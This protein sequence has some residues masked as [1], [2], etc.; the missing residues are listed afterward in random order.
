MKTYK[1]LM[2]KEAVWSTIWSTVQQIVVAASTYFIL[3]A[4]RHITSGKLELALIYIGAFV[5]SLVLVYLP[6]T[7]SMVYLQR[8]RL[9]SVESFVQSFIHH[10]KGQTS[11]GHTRNKVKA[12]SWLTNES[13]TVLDTA[14]N[15]L[16]QIY[17]TLMNSVFNI[18]VIA[19][20]L[21][22]RILAWYAFAGAVLVASNYFF[23][24]KISQTSLTVQESRNEL[25][26]S[27]LSAW[28][29]IFVGNAHNFEIWNSDFSKRMNKT[30]ISATSY[31]LTR[32]LIS[33][34]TVSI[35]L[36]IVATGNGIFLWENRQS[37]SLMAALLIT[38]PRQLQIIQSI[39]AFFNL[40]LSWTGTREQLKELEKVIHISQQPNESEKYVSFDAIEMFNGQESCI[41]PNLNSISGRIQNSVAGRWTLRG[42]NG[43]GKS[44][45][46]SLLKEDLA[47]TAFLLPTNYEDLAFEKDFLNHSDGNR[48][49]SVFQRIASLDHVK[50][51]ILDEWDAN[52]DGDN[53]NH[54]NNMIE[55]LAT[56]KVVIE[57]RHR[58]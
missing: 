4:I 51:I 12:E 26:T 27:M 10:N 50:V 29:N 11:F 40:T 3:E 8:W 42:R 20:A 38:M 22:A 32:S 5:A 17:S 36:L 46:L 35:A 34:G 24:N 19:L 57:S 58:R 18:L 48:I 6:N 31:D 54:I 37:V 14:T 16:Y 2:N 52:L 55:I 43:A 9:A 28:Q 25:S 56:N 41:H 1:I 47:E 45:L 44:T 33:S 15:L 39:F 7:L 30:K 21:D 53:L 13:F 23:R 49:L